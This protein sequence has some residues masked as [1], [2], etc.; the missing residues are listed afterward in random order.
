MP[1]PPLQQL[2]QRGVPKQSNEAKWSHAV[3]VGMWKRARK[4]MPSSAVRAIVVCLG[5]LHL[6]M[7]AMFV[8]L[9]CMPLV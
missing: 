5:L 8:G 7:H 6:S 2:R 3:T 4:L 9:Q 1:H